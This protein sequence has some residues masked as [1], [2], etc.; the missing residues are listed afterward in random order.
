MWKPANSFSVHHLYSFFLSLS[1]DYFTFPLASI[2]FLLLK[3]PFGRSFSMIFESRD[4]FICM[5]AD[6]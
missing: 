6:F 4:Q 5:Q 3:I 2:N 1:G